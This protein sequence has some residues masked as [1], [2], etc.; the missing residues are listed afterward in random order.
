MFVRVV[1]C[2]SRTIKKY[3]IP[4]KLSKIIR[5]SSY[6][7]TTLCSR[8]PFA[9]AFIEGG[10]LLGPDLFLERGVLLEERRDYCVIDAC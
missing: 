2:P 8:F 1:Y 6:A 3:N 5:F 4:S 10:L 7:L 9:P